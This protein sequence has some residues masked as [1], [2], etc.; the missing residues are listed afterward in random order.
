VVPPV[1][2]PDEEVVPEVEL[3]PVLAELVPPLVLPAAVVPPLVVVA[4]VV[5][6]VVAP[7]VLEAL[8]VVP[9]S[10][11]PALEQANNKGVARDRSAFRMGMPL[12]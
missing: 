4:A 3:L 8:V 1:L 5:P 10:S 11:N 12:H 7:E 6:L 2:P 9:A